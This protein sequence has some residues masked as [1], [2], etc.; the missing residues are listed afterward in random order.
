MVSPQ[1]GDTWGGRSPL[2][3]VTALGPEFMSLALH[4]SPMHCDSDLC[5]NN[6]E[7]SSYEWIVLCTE[8]ENSL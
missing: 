5:K 3:L 6:F 7:K 2:S 8:I 1:N 4:L